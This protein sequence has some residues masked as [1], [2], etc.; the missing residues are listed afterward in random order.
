MTADASASTTATTTTTLRFAQLPTLAGIRPLP[1]RASV[2]GAA[3]GS[4]YQEFTCVFARKISTRNEPR[5]RF[6]ILLTD[7]LVTCHHALLPTNAACCR[8]CSHARLDRLFH[9]P[10]GW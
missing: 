4:V 7:W 1:F 8:R 10:L 3:L 9:W 5:S 6:F 2:K